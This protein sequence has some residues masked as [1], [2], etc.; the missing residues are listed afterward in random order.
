MT[1]PKPLELLS[2][3]AL[4]G[5][6]HMVIPD[7]TRETGRAVNLNV[8]TIGVVQKKLKSGQH[9]DLIIMSPAAIA[10]MEA[11]ETVLEGSA[12]NIC[13]AEAGIGV[14][15]GT[16]FPNVATSETFKHALLAARTI[17]ATD[18]KAGGTAGVHFAKLL[19]GMGIADEVRTKLV[20][21][22][23][24][25]AVIETIASGE[26]EFGITFISELMLDKRIA[27]VG[28]LPPEMR[29]VNTY[30]AAIPVMSTAI[31]AAAALTEFLTS[32]KCRTR[33]QLVGLIPA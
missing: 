7:F 28:P 29:L 8:G 33:F 15:A 24:G 25:R 5:L 10:A 17:T 22:D 18:P 26:A 27:V 4:E 30:T 32:P 3:G 16:S 13:H 14:R 9:A 2:A 20:L 19:E 1:Q 23:T 11:D 12:K 6:L 31:D 21:W